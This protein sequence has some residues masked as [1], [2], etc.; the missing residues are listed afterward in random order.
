MEDQSLELHKL[1][2]LLL[3]G[4]VICDGAWGTEIQKRGWRGEFPADLWN[5]T[6]PDEIR[7]ISREYRNAGS[8]I[9]LTNT[10]RANPVDLADFGLAEHA[11]EIN[12]RGVELARAGSSDRCSS[13]VFGSIGPIGR[14]NDES[15]VR[16][17]YSLQAQ[18]LAEAGVDALV[19]ETMSDIGEA[20]LAIEAARAT[21]LPLILSFTFD[22]HPG[23]P[24]TPGGDSPETVARAMLDAGAHGV[25]ANCGTHPRTFPEICRRMAAVCD[26][27]LWMKPSAGLPDF[28]S[29]NPCYSVSPSEFAVYGA[30]LI[31]A[32]AHFVGGCCGTSPRYIAALRNQQDLA[33]KENSRDETP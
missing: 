11:R 3:A 1:R 24:R 31:G 25:G 32:G 19:F 27:P 4:P 2:Q 16:L 33:A 29:G 18:Y 6:H 13:R 7:E 10:F 5:L 26:L 8:Q 17:G 23:Q 30:L 12:R 9:M 20:K 28:R 21:Q 22:D 15:T 14:R